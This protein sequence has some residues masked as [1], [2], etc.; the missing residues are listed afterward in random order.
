[1]IAAAGDIACDP[2]TPAFNGG[3]GTNSDCR[4][5]STS[6]LLVGADAVLPLGDDQYNCG[7]TSAFAQSYDPT[8]GRFKSI[9]Y[10]VPA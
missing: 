5:K 3:N 8:W 6:D 9:T 7:G 1:M 4:A 2:A 10:P